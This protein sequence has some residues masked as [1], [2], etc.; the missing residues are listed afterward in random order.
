MEVRNKK[1]ISLF[2]YLLVSHLAFSMEAQIVQNGE[3]Q[4]VGSEQVTLT[5]DFTEMEKV[6]SEFI[7]F[8]ENLVKEGKL[9]EMP[10]VGTAPFI[11]L[12]AG[13]K[14][15]AKTGIIFD[16]KTEEDDKKPSLLKEKK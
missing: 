9:K 1:Y 8:L 2:A 10:D 6:K 14:A 11:Y 13:E 4:T 12:Q 7:K 5:H 15:L 16:F 3:K